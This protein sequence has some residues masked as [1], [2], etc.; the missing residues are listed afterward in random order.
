MNGSKRREMRKKPTEITHKQLDNV[1]FDHTLFDPRKS[2]GNE[3][4]V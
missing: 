4:F 2:N 3:E 1:N